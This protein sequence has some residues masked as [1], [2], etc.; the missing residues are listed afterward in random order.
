MKTQLPRFGYKNLDA[1]MTSAERGFVGNF[2]FLFSH[3]IKNDLRR[4]ARDLHTL[5]GEGLAAP[6]LADAVRQFSRAV[7]KA[8]SIVSGLMLEQ[9]EKGAANGKR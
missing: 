6:R 9:E 7:V 1:L 8:S 2:D 4:V 3:A 5:A